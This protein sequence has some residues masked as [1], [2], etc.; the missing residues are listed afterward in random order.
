MWDTTDPNP[1]ADAWPSAQL[2]AL[3]VH[4]WSTLIAQKFMDQNPSIPTSSSVGALSSLA[5]KASTWLHSQKK[6]WKGLFNNG[7]T[8]FH[9]AVSPPMQTRSTSPAGW[10]AL[11]VSPDCLTVA[12]QLVPGGENDEGDEGD[13]VAERLRH[14]TAVSAFMSGVITANSDGDCAPRVAP[15]EFDSTACGPD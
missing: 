12:L 8:C 5:G 4:P 10:R 6:I 9:Q 13:G 14:M 3:K 7:T 1:A 15:R 2:L 11:F